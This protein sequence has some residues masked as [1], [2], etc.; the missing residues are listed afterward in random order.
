MS[1]LVE[2][3][4]V[5]GLL[6]AF[7]LPPSRRAATGFPRS[8]AAA[9]LVVVAAWSGRAVTSA[10]GHNQNRAFVSS[11]G[12][13][14]TMNA[15]SD[16]YDAKFAFHHAAA[17]V[18]STQD[19]ARRLLRE[20]K[21]QHHRKPLA[22][23]AD[24]QTAGRGTQGRTWLSS[25]S[26]PGVHLTVCLPIDRVPV[27]LTLLPLQVGVL[28]A[29]QVSRQLQACSGA[30]QDNGTTPGKVTVKWPNDVLVN[31]LKISGT[32]IENE[33]VDDD[34]SNDN[35]WLLIGMGINVHSVPTLTGPGRHR[36]GATCL[37]DHCS[38]P[39][40]ADAHVAIARDLAE[41][42]VD[43]AVQDVSTGG[44]KETDVLEQW[45]S[46]AVFG[47]E[48]ELRGQVVDEEGGGYEGERVVTLGI[49]PTGQ[50]RVRGSDGRERLLVADYLF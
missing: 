30:K 5:L 23:L 37:Q 19:E 32:L 25:E 45:Q 2:P 46:F 44:E 39:L 6:M 11:T 31:D 15:S 33:I 18:S 17:P 27:R 47:V 24:A 43:W 26:G 40:S 28:V 48:Y 42:L 29:Q 10:R 16:D 12:D 4:L 3:S 34:D 49:H 7:L 35:T 36:R 22:V 38:Q 21:H 41:S 13:V 50:L 9:A 1:T 20:W 14:A 8:T